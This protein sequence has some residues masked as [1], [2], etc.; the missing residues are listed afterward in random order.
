MA[1]LKK[2]SGVYDRDDRNA[3]QVKLS[4]RDASGRVHKIHRWFP[5]D[6]VAPTLSRHGKSKVRDDAAAFAA[7]ERA[8]LR[9]E[10]RPA[11]ELIQSQ[12]L[13]RW[14]DDYE[15]AQYLDP[16]PGRKVKKGEKQ[17]R[18]VLKRLREDYP[19][20][21]AKPVLELTAQD[22]DTTATGLV[23]KMAHGWKDA[24]G[25]FR[26]G[27]KPK[28]IR[29][30]FAVLAAVWK[31][32]GKP[33]GLLCPFDVRD[34]P[35]EDD[36][37]ERIVSD[38]ELTS[39]LSEMLNRSPGTRAA[40]LFLRWTA[41]RRSE[42]A[43]LQWPHLAK[44]ERGTGSAT[45]HD[46]KTPKRGKVKS[47]TVPVPKPVMDEILK[48]DRETATVFDCRAD[49]LTNAWD[50]SCKR[51]G[52]EDARLHDLRHTRIT[53]LVGGGMP[54]LE[55]SAFTGHDDIRM[56]RRYY[57]PRPEAIA[58]AMAQADRKT[59]AD[60]RTRRR[61]KPSDSVKESKR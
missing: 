56:L 30:Y 4:R 39:I 42:A 50:E 38:D 54:I 17:E 45:L 41:A 11:P 32:Y 47:R 8:A 40:I 44:G 20:L 43:K 58:R 7:Q 36:T 18:S 48:L 46:T 21:L 16:A 57:N 24:A 60:K 35:N 49:S 9:I 34:L 12:T 33:R 6:P 53:E 52:I 55:L 10:K 15:T 51:A 26:G 22:F 59:K 19:D 25:E 61:K 31:E 5:Y 29:R 37:R 2:I 28:T 27:Y 14:L 23:G 3:W 13:G 1:Q